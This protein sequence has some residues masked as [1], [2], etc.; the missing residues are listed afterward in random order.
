MLRRTDKAWVSMSL[1]M[2][3]ESGLVLRALLATSQ[4][5]DITADL[6]T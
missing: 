2:N 4:R 3:A 6:D 1:L 5:S